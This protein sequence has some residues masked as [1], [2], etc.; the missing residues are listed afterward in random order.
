M[1]YLLYNA[2]S[3]KMGTINY[4][5]SES[6]LDF[7]YKHINCDLIE[8]VGLAPNID[9]I[10]DE[11]GLLKPY[12]KVNVVRDSSTGV[13]AH[14]VGNMMFAHVENG[15]VTDL[16]KDDLLYLKRNVS[17]GSVS[18]DKYHQIN[19]LNSYR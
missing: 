13:R 9:I 11:E 4:D 14:L 2:E 10:V 3:E 8:H 16:T 15:E 5:E 6:F 17:I 19:I 1:S 18:V 7:S 12:D